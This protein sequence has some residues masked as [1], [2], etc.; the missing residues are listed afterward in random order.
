MRCEIIAGSDSRAD[1]YATAEPLPPRLRYY[2]RGR[3]W[4][5]QRPG[6]VPTRNKPE[7]VVLVIVWELLLEHKYMRIGCPADGRISRHRSPVPLTNQEGNLLA[8][9]MSLLATLGTVLRTLPVTRIPHNWEA[10]N[11][12]SPSRFSGLL[13]STSAALHYQTVAHCLPNHTRFSPPPRYI[14]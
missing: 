5:G 12:S 14:V 4:K 1:S 3:K 6:E 10:P 7:I 9:S 11:P 13:P 2:S 8:A